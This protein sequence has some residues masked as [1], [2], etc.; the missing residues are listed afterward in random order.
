MKETL[1]VIIRGFL[2]IENW[3]P[4]SSQKHIYKPYTQDFRIVEDKYRQL[5]DLLEKNII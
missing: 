4:N 2:Y 5:F 3:I 1:N